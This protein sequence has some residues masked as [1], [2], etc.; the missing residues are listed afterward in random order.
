MIIPGVDTVI[1]GM[2]VSTR[3]LRRSPEAP[4]AGRDA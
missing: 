3:I 2:A 1:F 4:A